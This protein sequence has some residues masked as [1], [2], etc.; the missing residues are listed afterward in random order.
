[1]AEPA[2]SFTTE[3]L[4]KLISRSGLLNDQ[5]FESQKQRF[6]KSELKPKA[7]LNQM[8]AEHLFTPF[9]AKQLSERR[10]RG[11]F[12]SDKYKILDFLGQGGMSRVLLC[13]HLL[14]QRLVAV[15]ILNKSLEKFPGAAERFLREARASASMDH[16]NI[17]RVFDVDR[18][19]LG[20][21]IVMEY[22]DGT[23]LHELA[24]KNGLLDIKRVAHY[25]RQAAI[26][27]QHAHEA[28]LVH[29]DVKPANVML[30]RT[31][32][33][34]LLDLGLA[35]FFDPTRSD[36]LTQQI[37]AASII[38]TA[39]YIAPEQVMESSSAD[40]RADIYSLGYTM[41]F[42]L[43][44]ILP[45]GSGPA[46]RKLIW[47]QTR[48][49][50][51]IRSIRPEVPE[52]MAAVLEK[53]IKKRPEER[54]QTPMEV[55]AALDE[56]TSSPIPEPSSEEMPRTKATAY[57]LGLC[58]PPDPSKFA[59]T[60]VPKTAT[61]SP[62]PNSPQPV[63]Q[64]GLDGSPN[65]QRPAVTPKSDSSMG[66]TNTRDVESFAAQE[67]K[68]Q[69][70]DTNNVMSASLETSS[71]PGSSYIRVLSNSTKLIKSNLSI[72]LIVL[73]G[74]SIAFLT[75]ILANR[76]WSGG[77]TTAPSQASVPRADS[78]FKE[79]TNSTAPVTGSAALAVSPIGVVLRGGGS[80]FI[81]PVME[82]WA[83]SY[84][85]QTGIKIEYSAVGSTKGIEGFLSNFLDFGCTDAYMSDDQLAE[86]GVGIIHVP[87]AIGAVV[88]TFNVTDDS[89]QPIA[90][91]FTGATLANIFLGKVKRWNDPAITV[92][93]PGREFPDLPITVV[94]RKDGSGTTTI[95]TDYL[96]KANATW[97]AQIGVG[98]KV[99]WPVGVGAEK[100]HGIA[101]TVSRTP[102]AIGYVELSY[103]IA[104][105]LSVGQVM[106]QSGSYVEPTV[107]SITA[108]ASASMKSIPADLRFSMADAPGPNAYPIIGAT[109]AI[110]RQD[111]TSDRGTALVQFLRWATSEG[112]SQ[113]ASLQYSRL[114]PEITD[115]IAQL[116]DKVI[117]SK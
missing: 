115:R 20:P 109:W 52:A 36:N 58:P 99:S 110:L 71:T 94:F 67:P 5:L 22:V 100:N 117:V 75:G 18:T 39:D 43:T 116:L 25:I 49:P 89:G 65:D 74:I 79:S 8:L 98:S 13:E 103:A 70:A 96:S 29:R 72:S 7:I 87:L 41:Y 47:H 28:G 97:K 11:F 15:K 44:Q 91:R 84:Q 86:A 23:N 63:A 62:E 40:I 111:Q 57:R 17:A 76:W 95:W 54:Y 101:D 46:M 83:E 1:M 93:N 45:A 30:D 56:W 32:V 2:T 37:D 59:E 82:V 90:I 69:T 51:P 107:E 33:I 38:G 42:L 60:S 12:L 27:L 80:T 78:S 104:N 113:L 10:H 68:D 26:G 106:N 66:Y 9:Q 114:P 48:E 64:A 55:A 21:C 77:R 6:L 50:D 102:G 92:N 4:F 24:V 34:K 31:G 16:P 81:R 35:R 53:M 14:L 85:K 88:P 108:A 19:G 61:T 112:Q 3:D 73:L 105:S